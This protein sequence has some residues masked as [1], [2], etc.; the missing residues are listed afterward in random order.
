LE[1]KNYSKYLL[2]KT[3]KLPFSLVTE[4]Y[5]HIFL[6]L[7]VQIF[8]DTHFTEFYLSSGSICSKASAHCWN[9]Y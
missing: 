7:F 1:I 3:N 8:I 4:R 9:T 6:L 2:R 5:G